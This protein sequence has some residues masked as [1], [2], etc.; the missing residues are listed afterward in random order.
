MTLKKKI[1]LEDDSKCSNKE[2]KY[3]NSKWIRG[4]DVGFILNRLHSVVDIYLQ[5]TA[6]DIAM[7]AFL[8]CFWQAIRSVFA[9]YEVFIVQISPVNP[10][11]FLHLDRK[12]IYW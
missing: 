12:D 5:L 1:L 11:T 2:T 7:G 10:N 8:I 6:F 9:V 3:K 4:S